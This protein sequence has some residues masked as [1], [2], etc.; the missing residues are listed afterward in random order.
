MVTRVPFWRS[1]KRAE[2][3]FFAQHSQLMRADLRVS[4]PSGAVSLREIESGKRATELFSKLLMV[5]LTATKPER[6]KLLGFALV[7]ITLSV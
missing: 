3:A 4:T 5:A 2:S 7:A 1:A 6:L